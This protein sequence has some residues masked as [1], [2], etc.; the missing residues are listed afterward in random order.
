MID[1]TKA[2]TR[3]FLEKSFKGATAQKTGLKSTMI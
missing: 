1:R 3:H 2:A